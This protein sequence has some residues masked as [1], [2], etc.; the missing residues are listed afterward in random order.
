MESIYEIQ[1]VEL[2]VTKNIYIK[3]MKINK[4]GYSAN[5]YSDRR[6]E[7][8]LQCSTEYS[9]F[10]IKDHIYPTKDKAVSEELNRFKG[11][12]DIDGILLRDSAPKYDLPDLDDYVHKN[13][14]DKLEMKLKHLR[15]VIYILT[16]TV[17]LFSVSNIINLMR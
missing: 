13:E 7:N 14:L 6:C 9:G 17:I 12:D 1:K 3:V 8:L 2:P 16:A 11:N 15:G 4:E 10:V 5:I